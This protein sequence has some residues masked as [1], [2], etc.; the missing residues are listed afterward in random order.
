ME[1]QTPV[2]GTVNVTLSYE[3]RPLVRDEVGPGEPNASL[4]WPGPPAGDYEVGV[5]LGTGADQ[6]YRVE[7][8]AVGT[9]D[10]DESNRACEVGEERRSRG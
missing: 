4:L 2:T 3:D 6:G 9:D 10:G 5:E 8:C 1:A 7:W